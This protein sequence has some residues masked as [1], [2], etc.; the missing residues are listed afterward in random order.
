[1]ESIE[2]WQTKASERSGR[3]GMWIPGLFIIYI[4]YPSISLSGRVLGTAR[5][6][7]VGISNKRHH[8][9]LIRQPRSSNFSSLLQFL[10]EHLPWV[11]QWL[12]GGPAAGD[13]RCSWGRRSGRVLTAPSATLDAWESVLWW[14]CVHVYESLGSC[15]CVC[16]RLP[17]KWHLFSKIHHSVTCKTLIR[18]L[19]TYPVYF[20]NYFWSGASNTFENYENKSCID[21][22][23]CKKSVVKSDPQSVASDIKE[24]Q[25]KN[26]N[27]FFVNDSQQ[28]FQF[29]PTQHPSCELEVL[30]TYT[31][32][33]LKI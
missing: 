23:A 33:I 27:D 21:C 17:F 11:L 7:W 20:D 3:S 8:L 30:H 2:G 9:M 4:I 5:M 19:E 12:A 6:M 32:M 16:L 25:N 14:L 18:I 24:K 22:Y 13:T 31:I 15:V 26:I 1:M 28:R 10:D 29:W